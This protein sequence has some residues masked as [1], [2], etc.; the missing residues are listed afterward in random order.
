MVLVGVE[1][2]VV[3]FVVVF[4]DVGVVSVFFLVAVVCI[5]SC[6]KQFLSWLLEV[7]VVVVDVVG[8]W[9]SGVCC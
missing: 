6:P 2:V 7:V 3:V 5:L 1:D 8:G 9:G 4:I